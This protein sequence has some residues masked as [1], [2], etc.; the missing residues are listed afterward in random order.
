VTERELAQALVQGYR[1]PSVK[2]RPRAL[3]IFVPIILA[4]L[5]LSHPAWSAG[6]VSQ[7][8]VAAGGWWLPLHLLLLA[9]YGILVWLLWVRD[10]L[11]RSLLVLFLLCNTAFLGLDG[12]GLGLLAAADPGAADRLW[13]SGLVVAL[14]NLTGATWAASLLSVAAYQ[15]RA[16]T[17]RPAWIGLGLTWI[18]F[19][20]SATP[21]AVP[22]LVSRLAAVATGGW[23][24]YATGTSGVPFALLVFAAVL[25][26]HVGAEAAF[27]LVL[28][29]IAQARLSQHG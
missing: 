3:P 2:R 14:A 1:E 16:S 20:A 28:V 27:G 21:L 26:Q 19:V 5:E 12:V 15:V 10:V 23:I 22:S 13:N 25:H 7:A 18:A 8:V 4:A 29:G 9:G 11:A 6:T 24:I 17:N